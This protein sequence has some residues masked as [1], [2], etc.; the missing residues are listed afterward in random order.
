MDSSR[1]LLLIGV[2]VAAAAAGVHIYLNGS[3][4]PPPSRDLH[5]ILG[6]SKATSD[7]DLRKLFRKL[8]VKWHPDKA[9]PSQRDE[10]AR[11]FEEISRAYKILTDPLERRIYDNL[12]D[13]GVQRWR[14]GG[15]NVKNV[16]LQTQFALEILH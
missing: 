10:H 3:G 5:A 14:D 7:E 9:T 15:R 11:T 12:G 16:N 8:A 4:V 13:R 6:A 2:L 1:R